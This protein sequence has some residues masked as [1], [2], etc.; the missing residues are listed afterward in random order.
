[1]KKTTLLKTAASVAAMGLL[2]TACGSDDGGDNGDATRETYQVG[3]AQ[4]V[5]HPSLDATAQ[6]IKDVLEESEHNFEI[7]EQNAQADQA[8]M[9]NIVGGYAG[10]T[11]LDAVA[12]IA[13]PVAI[14]AATTITDTPIVFSAVTDPVDAQLVPDWD[15]PGENI[16]GVSDMNPVDQQLQL[17]L[18]VVGDVEVIGI[19]YSSAESNSVVQVDAAKE[20]AEELGV[21]IQEVAV[22][23]TSEVAQGVESFD[24]VD[25]I[26]V[27]TDNTVVSGLETVISYGIDNQVPVFAAESDSVE[28]G[29]IGTYGLNY[30]EHGRQA[31]EM[32]LALVTGENELADTPPERA[33]EAALEY[34]FN[35]E[36]AEQ[37]GVEIPQ[38]LLEGANIT[39]ED[40]ATETNDTTDQ[41][42]DAEESAE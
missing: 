4:Y 25:A 10:D 6:G 18:D 38:D 2:L 41:E 28:R 17:I 9:N 26:Y 32:I 20:A 11:N 8:T 33:D 14:A 3:I 29:T 5:S 36:A 12:P 30:Y 19:P 35:L 34:T 37:M 39:G 40:D 22:T 24:N 7:E 42:T 21:E 31:G 16:T 1:M 15:T 13:T 27:P 23:N